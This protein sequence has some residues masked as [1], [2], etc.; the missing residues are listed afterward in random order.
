MTKLLTY[1]DYVDKYKDRHFKISQ[2]YCKPK[3]EDY[4]QYYQKMKE[5]IEKEYNS[6][7]LKIK[8]K[9]RL[10][11]AFLK[12]KISEDIKNIDTLIIK[13]YSGKTFHG[14]LNRWLMNCKFNFYEPVA[15]FTARLMFSLNSYANK[16]KKDQYSNEY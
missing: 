3:K 16:N 8:N 10:L 1:Q 13:E 15:Y 11:D 7:E 5:I 2:F 12:F 9:K 6:N 14:D 4:D